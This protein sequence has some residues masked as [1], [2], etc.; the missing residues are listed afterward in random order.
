MHFLDEK[1]SGLLFAATSS[2]D[3]FC[4]GHSLWDP[5]YLVR[6]AEAVLLIMRA[7]T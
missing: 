1:F 5:E 3:Y 4:L 6:T 7:Q 2:I